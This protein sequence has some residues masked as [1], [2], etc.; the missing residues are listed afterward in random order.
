MADSNSGQKRRKVAIGD[1][2]KL[3]KATMVRLP[4]GTVVTARG[5][6]RVEQTGEHKVIGGASFDGIKG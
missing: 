5:S 2:V 1:S 6:Y 4:D 3:G